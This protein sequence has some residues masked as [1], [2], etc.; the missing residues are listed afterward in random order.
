MLPLFDGNRCKLSGAIS[1]KKKDGMNFENLRHLRTVWS[2]PGTSADLV[3]TVVTPNSLPKIQNVNLIQRHLLTL[4][5]YNHYQ[6]YWSP[7]LQGN[8]GKNRPMKEPSYR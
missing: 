4:S 1:I 3:S 6:M 5:Y 2:T 7:F 8:L